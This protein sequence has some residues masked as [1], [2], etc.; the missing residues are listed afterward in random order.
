MFARRRSI[1]SRLIIAGILS[2]AIVAILAA[3]GARSYRL[4]QHSS[5]MAAAAAE[6]SVRLHLTLRA[7]DEI[8]LTEGTL[9]AKVLARQRIVDFDRSLPDLILA[10]DDPDLKA[11]IEHSFAPRWHAFSRAAEAFSRI[12]VIGVENEEAMATFGKLIHD[13]DELTRDMETWR[14][15]VGEAIA[16]ELHRLTE[17]ATVA[18]VLMVL[19]LLALFVWTYRGIMRPISDLLSITARVSQEGDYATRARVDPGDEIGELANGFNTMLDTIEDRNHHLA[20]QAA[21]LR[22]AR[23]LAEAGSRAKSEFLAAMSHEVR[24]P[25]NGILGMTELL[26]STPL[27]VQ[28]RRF[29]DTVYQSGEH[30]LNIIND[31][32]DFSKIEAG[33]LEIECINFNLRQLAEDVAYMFA[34][35]ATVKGLEMVCSV[36]HDL[37]VAV[38]GDPMRVRQILTNL[39]SNAVKFTS[40]GKIVIT[41]K[42]LDET[43][44]QAR[45]RFQVQD[46]GIGI[47]AEAQARLFGAFV[48]AD[49][50]TTRR[51]GGSG[52][53]LAISKGLVEAMQGEIGLHSESGR[54]TLFWF[55]LPLGKQNPDARLTAD[56]AGRLAGL[57]VLVVD[58]H[59]TNRELLAHQISGWSMHYTGAASGSEAL[60]ALAA[61]AAIDQPFDL[62]ILDLQMPA[63]DGFELARTIKS[64]P[65]HAALPLVM[66]SSVSVGGDD[67]DRQ[68]APVDYYLSKPARQSDLFDAI[69]TAISQQTLAVPATATPSPLPV[70]TS[71]LTGRVL[72]AEDN[73]VNQEVVAA[74]LASIGVNHTLVSNGR[75]A[76]AQLAQEHFDLVL[77]DCQMPEMDGFDATAAIRS[78]Q[79]EGTLDRYLPVVA[80]TAN[81]V[82]GDRERCLAAGMDDYLSKPFTREQLASVLGRWL[83]QTDPAPAGYADGPAMLPTTP[84]APSAADTDQ[85]IN[86]RALDAIRQLP[87]P[88]G[89]V[90]VQKVIDAYL[91]DTPPR[92]AQLRA[93]V[94]AGDAEA[95]RKSAHALKS[96]GANVGA[97]RL[98]AL[99]RE[100]EA[101]GRNATVDGAETL[102]TDLDE[103]LPRVLAALGNHRC[104]A[105]AERAGLET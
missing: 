64:N 57:R 89:A 5:A 49:S 41:V 55:E 23:D 75:A 56:L 44:E 93:A 82:E 3:A 33:K 7:L 72:V 9:S 95:L 28:Q 99:F 48:Q 11:Q 40:E 38:I 1:R 62:A 67:P 102:L 85:P 8:I 37:P 92:I 46:T 47:S 80:L 17:A 42:L 32:L 71:A 39:I 65:R 90:L 58:D 88:N 74:M 2:L 79:R 34:Q 52:L 101:L 50:S 78:R 4:M 76:I 24:T 18:A 43:A 22:D 69:A 86:P 19:A 36:P 27:S 105:K 54:G 13:A 96:S 87:G 53:G 70:P 15:N 35:P 45:F 61:A 21:E 12:R 81:A 10:T 66:L 91:T 104:S 51:F 59:A 83:A 68:A 94:D 73:A 98:S 14:V 16:A 30:L 31:I 26:R 84:D 103:E 100:L 97:E 29:A 77:M 63:M 6:G 20:V 25:M 60:Q